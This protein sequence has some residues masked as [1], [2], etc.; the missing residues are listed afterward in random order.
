[1]CRCFSAFTTS[2]SRSFERRDVISHSSS[3]TRR[4]IARQ[5]SELPRMRP[6]PITKSAA[7]S[8]PSAKGTITTATPDTVMFEPKSAIA[9]FGA[10]SRS[11]STM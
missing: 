7:A 11:F 6:I 1:M 8:A 3:A 10:V 9:W 2:L 4:F 5:L